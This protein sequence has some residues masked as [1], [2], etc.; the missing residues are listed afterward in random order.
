MFISRTTTVSVTSLPQPN[1]TQKCITAQTFEITYWQAVEVVMMKQFPPRACGDLIYSGHCCC[2]LIAVSI[3]RRHGCF[4][5][6]PTFLLPPSSSSSSS[7]SSKNNSSPQFN[8]NLLLH[9][10]FLTLIYVLTFLSITSI[11]LCRSHYTV[12]VILGTYF[13]FFLTDFY[14]HRASGEIRGSWVTVFLR[15]IEGTGEMEDEERDGLQKWDG[16]M[17]INEGDGE[18]EDDDDGDDREDSGEG[19]LIHH[20]HHHHHHR[21]CDDDDAGGCEDGES[22]GRKGERSKLLPANGKEDP[23]SNNQRRT[24]YGAASSSKRSTSSITGS[25]TSTTNGGGGGDDQRQQ[26]ILERGS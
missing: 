5:V 13:A 10:P 25:E 7:S 4:P 23:P 1:Y 21:C 9:I 3:F 24:E 18:E 26:Y 22:K 20:H 11:F 14:Y 6:I 12:D 2:A 15:W 17:I 16:G 8:S 19:G